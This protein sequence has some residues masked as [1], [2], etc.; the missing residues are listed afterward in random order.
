MAKRKNNGSDPVKRALLDE[1]GCVCRGL[2]RVF[3]R[4]ELAK[5]PEYALARRLKKWA[6]DLRAEKPFVLVT[7]SGGVATIWDTPG[8]DTDLVDWDNWDDKDPTRDELKYLREVAEQLQDRN[9]KAKFLREV[10]EL[11]DRGVAE[12]EE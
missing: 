8:V 1:L 11:E 2:E 12:D 6:K 5:D 7:V 4:A 10:Q 9:D 3:T